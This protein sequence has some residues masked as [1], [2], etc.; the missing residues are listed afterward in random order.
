MHGYQL[1]G[2][3]LG[4]APVVLSLL[5]LLAH[6]PIYKSHLNMRKVILSEPILLL[7]SFVYPS[8]LFFVVLSIFSSISPILM[9]LFPTESGILSFG[10]LIYYHTQTQQHED[11][12][13]EHTTLIPHYAFLPI[14]KEY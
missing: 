4:M 2:S 9:L 1:V 12:K 10:C 8:T 13:L 7:F 3:L 14:L 11:S 5:P 6:A